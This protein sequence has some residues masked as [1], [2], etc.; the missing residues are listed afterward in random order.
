MSGGFYPLVYRLTIFAW[1]RPVGIIGSMFGW[2]RLVVVENAAMNAV[3]I[4]IKLVVS[5]A[6]IRKCRP[7]HMFCIFIY[8]KIV[9]HSVLY[10]N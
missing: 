9:V 1:H 4:V 10:I 2:Q 6:E 7:S 8:I 3:L 5:F